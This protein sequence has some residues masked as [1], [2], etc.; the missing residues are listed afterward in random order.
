M[1]LDQVQAQAERLAIQV[2]EGVR[3]SIILNLAGATLTGYSTAASDIDGIIQSKMGYAAQQFW[4]VYRQAWEAGIVRGGTMDKTGQSSITPQ[5]DRFEQITTQAFKSLTQAIQSDVSI[6]LSRAALKTLTKDEVVKK[7][8]TSQGSGLFKAYQARAVGIVEYETFQIESFAARLR[9]IE[10]QQ[11]ATQ[12][13][14]I[15]AATGGVGS[16]Y[17]FMT[18]WQHNESGHPRPTHE[19]M[20]EKSVVTGTDFLLEQNDGSGPIM[21]P[22][23]H[24][25]NLNAGDSINCLCQILSTAHKVSPQVKQAIE[26]MSAQTNGIPKSVLMSLLAPNTAIEEKPAVAPILQTTVAPS[27]ALPSS[28]SGSVAQELK[29]GAPATKIAPTMQQQYAKS[30]KVAEII[31]HYTDDGF[32]NINRMLRVSEGDSLEGMDSK[33]VKFLDTHTAPIPAEVTTLYR[34]IDAESASELN[35]TVGGTHDDDGFT[36]VSTLA[37]V[38]RNFAGTKYYEDEDG[39]EVKP[40]VLVID[41]P[42]G[43]S[44]TDIRG[45]GTNSQE[46]EFILPR[47]S[48]LRIDSIIDG[49]SLNR[50][51]IDAF[52]TWVHCHIE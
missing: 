27:A 38:G 8:G 44:A 47:G 34:G 12:Q 30:K 46:S 4:P 15:I 31:N 5:L 19:D 9:A 3:Q 39:V 6:L 51:G 14:G 7:I 20:D 49:E 13:P 40:V 24:S 35:L 16:S 52:Y 50:Y 11:K 48:S 28:L 36:S 21:T 17:I 32:K 42:A 29:T 43:H 22:G 23:P 33:T 41:N 37:E 45:I 1:A 10:V 2:I 25:A 26:E 18:E